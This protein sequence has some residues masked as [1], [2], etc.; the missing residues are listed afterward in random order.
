MIQHAQAFGIPAHHRFRRHE[1]V[2]LHL[3]AVV[4]G[5]FSERDGKSWV[6]AGPGAVR[7]SGAARHDIDFGSD[8]AT[9]IVLH[10]VDL[11][12]APLAKPRF[13]D[14]D[15]WLARLVARFGVVLGGAASQ[16]PL[17]LDGLATELL[18]QVTRRLEGRAGPPPAWLRRVP[19]LVRDAPGPL[20]VSAIAAEIGVHRVH[21][22]RVFREHH[23]ISITGYMQR[24]RL[25]RA[26][27]ML[28]GDVAL[29]EVAAASGFSDQSHM[30]RAVR[31]AFGTTPAALRQA[32]HPFKTARRPPR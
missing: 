27:L 22:A 23:G 30:T 18:A 13:L 2:G 7:I 8:G 3:C 10:P 28:A 15:P 11:D 6:E 1:H 4:A 12:L 5:S 20:A 17:G 31:A 16:E 9:C 32:L 26:R 29:A 25:E 24:V 19:E 14:P 21:L